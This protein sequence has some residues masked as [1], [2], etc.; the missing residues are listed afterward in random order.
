M[1]PEDEYSPPVA[2]YRFRY[3]GENDVKEE[4]TAGRGTKHN[5]E[6]KRSRAPNPHP[7]HC[8]SPVQ[9]SCQP[10]ELLRRKGCR[11]RQQWRGEDILCL[12]P[13]FENAWKRKATNHSTWHGSGL[14]NASTII[15]CYSLSKAIGE[16]KHSCHM[17][18]ARALTVAAIG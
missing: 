6:T 9:C 18:D 1:N 15:S 10:F 12:R 3:E 4:R 17:L 11:W 16:K 14:G 7:G 2:L 8:R 13:L 5:S